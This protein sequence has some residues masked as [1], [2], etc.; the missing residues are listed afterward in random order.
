MPPSKMCYRS[1]IHVDRQRVTRLTALYAGQKERESVI[2]EE[3]HM[4][5]NVMGVYTREMEHFK[6]LEKKDE[7]SVLW[8][9]CEE[10]HEE[11]RMNVI[12]M[13]SNDAMARQIA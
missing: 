9:H 13:Y 8:R 6:A 12:E 2:E 7:R 4:K 3:S 1:R 5:L 11:F 10:K